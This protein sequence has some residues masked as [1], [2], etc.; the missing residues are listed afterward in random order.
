[1]NEKGRKLSGKA[2]SLWVHIRN[3][4][5]L[6]SIWAEDKTDDVLELMLLLSDI[7]V[8]RTASEFREREIDAL[9]MLEE[10]ETLLETET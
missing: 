9:D 5:L 3:F 10:L 6:V 8:R 2:C 4:P 7:T 1:M